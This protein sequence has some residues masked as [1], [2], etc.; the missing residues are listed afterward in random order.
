MVPFLVSYP[1]CTFT[2]SYVRPYKHRLGLHMIKNMQ[3][4]SFRVRVIL[5]PAFSE[6]ATLIQGTSKTKVELERCFPVKTTFC[7]SKRP[8][9]GSLHPHLVDGP[10]AP[11]TTARDQVQ[12]SGLLGNWHTCGVYIHIYIHIKINHYKQ[13]FPS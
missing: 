9:L 7:S 1:T 2:D 13:K 10:Q 3:L 11:V 5:T 8:K 12:S 4:L 6:A